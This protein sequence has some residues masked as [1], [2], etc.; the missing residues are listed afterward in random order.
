MIPLESSR[1]DLPIGTT[2]DRFIKSKEK[3]HPHAAGELSQLLRDIALAAKVVNR[4]IRKAG[5]VDIY[6]KLDQSNTGGEQ[7]QK[8][9]ILANSRFVRALTKGGEAAGIISEETDTFIDFHNS[10]KYVVAIDPLDGSSNID[11]N[12]SIGTI[13]S[14]Y[15]RPSPINTALDTKDFLQKGSNQVVGGYIVYG[16]STMLVFTTGEGVNAFTYEHSLGEFVL[17]QQN[18]KAGSASNIYSINDG[19]Y[20]S[21]TDQ[22]VKKYLQECRAKKFTARYIGSLVADFHRNLLK[23]GIFLYPGTQDY[24]NGKLRLMFEANPLAFIIE[25]AGGIATDGITPIL[26][27]EPTTFHQRTKLFIGS[28]HM[29][30]QLQALF[31]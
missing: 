4:E 9:D 21:I 2:L 16:P 8:L 31:N 17:S 10:G 1:I 23:G 5:L 29:V 25:Q 13:F 30:S 20:D 14:I 28:E 19:L 11:V 7:Q 12:V 15:K 22:A 18:I 24:P 26:D 27:L 6:G 3:N